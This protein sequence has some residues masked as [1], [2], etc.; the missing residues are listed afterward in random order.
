MEQR[1]YIIL[2][3]SGSLRKRSSN[4]RLLSFIEQLLPE[5]TEFRQFDGLAALPHFNPDIDG[6]EAEVH[7][8]VREWRLNVQEADAVVICTPEYARGVPGSLKNALDWVVSSGE[9]VSKPTAIISASPHA[10]GGAAAL[11]SLKLT[12]TMM[13][14]DLPEHASLAIPYISKIIE[15]DGSVSEP[16]MVSLLCKLVRSLLQAVSSK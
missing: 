2:G 3:I 4:T 13:T 15:Q 12:L 8:K 11:A 10:D 5:G 7:D 1:R 16:H 6:V 14:A 9:F